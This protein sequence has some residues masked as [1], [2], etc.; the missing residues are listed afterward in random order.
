VICLEVDF[1][2]H[3]RKL[4][5]YIHVA[6][7]WFSNKQHYLS[8]STQHHTLYKALYCI[9][10]HTHAYIHIHICAQ[11]A[12]S[13]FADVYVG[14]KTHLCKV[15]TCPCT[16]AQ[17]T[18]KVHA[19]LTAKKCTHIYTYTHMHMHTYAKFSAQKMQID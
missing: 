14:L 3:I 2:F 16:S 19:T 7:Y 12:A 6:S 1:L 10:M 5:V 4:R 8:R 17:N 15:H 18:C 13:V 9:C 11:P